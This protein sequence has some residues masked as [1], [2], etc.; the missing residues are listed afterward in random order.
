MPMPELVPKPVIV[1]PVQPARSLMLAVVVR[2]HDNDHGNQQNDADDDVS[3]RFGHDVLLD[4]TP[5]RKSLGDFLPSGSI[6]P[7]RGAE[8]GPFHT[9]ADF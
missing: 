9:G 6:V 4:C 3:N 7:F 2:R 8:T 5:L 1:E